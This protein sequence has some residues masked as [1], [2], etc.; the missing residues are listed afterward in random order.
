MADPTWRRSLTD[1]KDL[2]VL[3][4]ELAVM[5][6]I[7]QPELTLSDVKSLYWTVNPLGD[8]LSRFLFQLVAAGV[9]EQHPEDDTL[10]RWNPAFRGFWENKRPTVPLR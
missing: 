4:H 5:L 8:A 7:V 2:D 9:L 3:Q 1:W 6:G 10:L